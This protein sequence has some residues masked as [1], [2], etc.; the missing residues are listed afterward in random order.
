[1]G[2]RSVTRGVGGGATIDAANVS[3]PRDIV[4][5]GEQPT[6]LL[7]KAIMMSG[8]ESMV[9]TQ[10]REAEAILLELEP[11]IAVLFGEEVPE[12]I[13]VEPFDVSERTDR[14]IVNGLSIAINAANVVAQGA[15]LTMPVQGLV[16][17][18]PET[19]SNLAT[20]QPVMK[21]GYYLGTLTQGGKYAASIGWLPATGALAATV[22]ASAGTAFALLAI[23]AQLTSIS[24][25][26][27]R[28]LQL[29]EEIREEMKASRRDKLKALNGAVERMFAKVSRKGRIER[30]DLEDLSGNL[31]SSQELT[32]SFKRDVMTHVRNIESDPAKGW[33]Y[34]VNRPGE[35]IRDVY[36]CVSVCHTR[37]RLRM[38]DAALEVAEA[39]EGDE[40]RHVIEG[41]RTCLSEDLSEYVSDVVPLLDRL[42]VAFHLAK[43]LGGRRR[44]AKANDSGDVDELESCLAQWCAQF[45]VERLELEPVVTVYES[46]APRG[47][48]EILKWKLPADVPLLALAEIRSQGWMSGVKE[49]VSRV[50]DYLAVTPER[51]HVVNGSVLMKSGE[52][53][54]GTALADIRYVRRSVGDE[55]ASLE[56]ITKQKN[57]PVEFGSWAN[58]EEKSPGVERLADLLMSAANIPEDEQRSDS[59]LTEV[60]SRRQARMLVSAQSMES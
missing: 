48:L 17:L 21:E 60:T 57:V 59:L 50:P 26:Q 16:R 1:M 45:H 31:K 55:G 40:S 7:R 33:A 24:Q 25:K 9:D 5:L 27:D 30:D 36:A 32:E 39:S 2:D 20:M 53:A 13:D 56:V 19:L 51:F 52:L 3:H 29:T 28:V 15:Q 58:A 34:L 54:D 22:I 37:M 43:E 44:K 12:G 23:S 10:G 8:T 35:I 41:A 47:V 49:R 14:Q 4:F 46:E 38:L 6:A 42:N 18:S 11:G